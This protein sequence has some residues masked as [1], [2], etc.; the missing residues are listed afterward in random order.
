M[1]LQFHDGKVIHWKEPTVRVPHASVLVGA[2]R[3]GG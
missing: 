2:A 3:A 1:L